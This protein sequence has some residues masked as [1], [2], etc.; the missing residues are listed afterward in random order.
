MGTQV[1]RPR[2]EPGW[3]SA[4]AAR[5][6]CAEWRRESGKLGTLEPHS[7]ARGSPGDS[8]GW[9]GERRAWLEPERLGWSGA[10]QEAEGALRAWKRGRGACSEGASPQ[11]TGLLCGA[12]HQVLESGVLPGRATSSCLTAFRPQ[13][14]LQGSLSESLFMLFFSY[15]LKISNFPYVL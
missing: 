15:P 6:P 7:T 13:G 9:F 4:E 2:R 1:W 14:A 5:R 10:L 12:G 8:E 3:R 11:V